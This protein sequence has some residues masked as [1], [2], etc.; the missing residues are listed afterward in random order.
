MRTPSR[1]PWMQILLAALAAA[2]VH[3]ILWQGSYQVFSSSLDFNQGALEDF[4]GVYLPAARGFAASAESVPGFLYAPFFAW[5]LQ[6]LAGLG[7]EAAS[8]VWLVWEL[9]V[10]A[11]LLGVGGYWVSR[12]VGAAG[13]DWCLPLYVFLG[14]LSLPLVHNLHWGQISTTL[15]LLIV[16]AAGLRDRRLA[17][18]CIGCAAAIKFYPA[19][20]FLLFLMGRDWRGLR[21][22]LGTW[23]ALS[24]LPGFQIGFG[25][26]ASAHGELVWNLAQ[27][28]GY[29]GKWFTAANNQSLAATAARWLGL[30]GWSLL[31]SALLGWAV[32]LLVLNSCARL[33]GE[34]SAL[35]RLLA[36]ALLT[37]CLP[38]VLSPSWPHYFAALPF[39]QL[40]LVRLAGADRLA[41][42]CVAVSVLLSSSLLFRV[43][44]DPERYGAW[45]LLLAANLV[46]LPTALCSA[47]RIIRA[48][49]D[50]SSCAPV[51]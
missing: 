23:V 29:E 40:L 49:S 37:L 25:S 15:A 18:V 33:M 6:P 4:M 1:S 28:T 35:A 2:G 39:A 12:R 14:V 45:G 44:D 48:Q 42:A 51:A 50:S 22:G 34:G 46:L 16:A 17:A 9:L 20:F 43:I 13:P 19:L 10:S 32:A 27:L 8:W 41:L 5:I 24:L 36:F 47:A 30:G 26:L 11:L 7:P 3:G 21:W 31:T 38:L